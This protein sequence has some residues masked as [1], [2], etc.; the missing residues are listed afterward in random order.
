METLDRTHK[1][2]SIPCVVP[3]MRFVEKLGRVE[4]RTGRLLD[5]VGRV[6]DGTGR[7]LDVVGRVKDGTGRLLDVVGRV[8]DGTGSLLDVVGRVQDGT[9]WGHA[10]IVRPLEHTYL[11]FRFVENK[12][13][14]G[15]HKLCRLVYS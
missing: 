7:L 6:K 8:K 3:F 4:D 12:L 15:L 1:Y 10:A 14:F 5:V 13:Q 2:T 11:G 9:E